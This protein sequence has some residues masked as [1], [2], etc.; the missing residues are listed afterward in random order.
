[1]NTKSALF[2]VLSVFAT[3]AVAVAATPAKKSGS[4]CSPQQVAQVESAP[5]YPLTVCVVSG[6]ELGSMGKPVDYT[7]QEAGQSD[8]LVRFCCAGCIKTF[9]K[10]PA[11]YLAQIDQAAQ[12]VAPVASCTRES[13]A[14]SACH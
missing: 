13:A 3:A 5:A 2:F 11:K 8:R 9:K 4:C 6:E 12:A 1:M 7:H 10:D 14:K